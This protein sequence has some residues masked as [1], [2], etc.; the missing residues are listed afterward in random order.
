MA[1]K[2]SYPKPFSREAALEEME[3]TGESP[4]AFARRTATPEIV[5]AGKLKS[6]TACV[7]GWA[8]WAQDQG[9]APSSP[10][11]VVLEP[12]VI[13]MGSRSGK[14]P[15][16]DVDPVELTGIEFLEH[17]LQQ[18]ESDMEQ[19]RSAGHTGSLAQ[20]G[21]LSIE[22]REKL[23]AARAAADESVEEPDPIPAELIAEIVQLIADPEMPLRMVDA[24]QEAC[25]ARR[26]RRPPE[27]VH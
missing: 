9:R 16:P 6:W 20:L 10:P 7:R 8:R 13:R 25:E 3:R 15:P 24:I 21:K 27:A 12:E 17:R 14:S 26:E 23:E 19:A 18:L 4:R 22:T 11:P 1:R 2:T 5:Q